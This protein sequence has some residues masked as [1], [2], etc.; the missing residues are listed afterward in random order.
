MAQL[1]FFGL[2][3][4]PG[5]REG[6]T[7]S[8][9]AYLLATGFAAVTNAI[10]IP[11]F[12]SYLPPSEYGQLSIFQSVFSM[13]TLFTFFSL[14]P[15]IVRELTVKTHQDAPGY[16]ST[17]LAIVCVLTAFLTGLI[18]LFLGYL[19][20]FLDLPV[21]MIVPALVCGGAQSVYQIYLAILQAEGSAW[22]YAIIQTAL[23]L[24]NV[25]LSIFFLIVVD[26]G[27]LSRAI[28][29]LTSS[30]IGGGFAISAIASRK[31][32]SR[33]SAAYALEMVT[34]S[35]ATVLATIFV[36][37]FDRIMLGGLF[38]P[39]DAGLYTLSSQLCTV[40][41]LAS[42]AIMLAAA[43]WAYRKMAACQTRADW[44]SFYR[45]LIGVAI[46]VTLIAVL[47]GG[48]VMVISL[49]FARWRYA[50]MLV[51]FPW[52]LTASYF[53]ALHYVF[54]PVLYYFKSATLITASA[55]ALVSTNLISLVV[56]PD[57]LGSTGVPAALTLAR[58]VQLA[59]VIGMGI[60]LMRDALKTGNPA[61]E[62]GG[63]ED[64][65]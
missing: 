10:L 24:L 57:I 42:S 50:E 45:K 62:A 3:A 53:L 19:K 4:L 33:A 40:V 44:H 21:W 17:A 2:G 9:A 38:S 32:I 5:M 30:V 61:G 58:L 41:T 14:R 64:I 51:Y 7:Q 55:I 27:W 54:V 22:R 36:A 31:L 56:L 47:F 48:V 25:A 46:I 8:A 1:K 16:I 52:S 12:V 11:I 26:W 59:C 37:N 60:F 43:P 39:R 13:A 6:V 49:R 28:G 15:P 65:G 18:A 34:L 35:G 63:L 20:S 29:F 23:L